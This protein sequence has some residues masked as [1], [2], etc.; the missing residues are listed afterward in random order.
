MQKKM[1]I[2]KTPEQECAWH[3]RRTARDQCVWK[4]EEEVLINVLKEVVE[5]LNRVGTCG[6]CKVLG[7]YSKLSIEEF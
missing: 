6:H 7:F 4:N 1:A 5:G 3:I 2:A